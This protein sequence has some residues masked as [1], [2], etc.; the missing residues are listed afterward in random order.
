MP[1]LNVVVS[2]S[3][4]LLLNINKSKIAHQICLNISMNTEEY[5]TQLVLR[6][7]EIAKKNILF[8]ISMSQHYHQQQYHRMKTFCNPD[9]RLTHLLHVHGPE[10]PL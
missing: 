8:S 1:K 6:K 7:T 4:Q 3:A 9:L 2:Q 10:I 5:C